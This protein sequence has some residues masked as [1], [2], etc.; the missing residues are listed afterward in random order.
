M[1][2][3]QKFN[4]DLEDRESLMYFILSMKEKKGLSKEK[5]IVLLS[6]LFEEETQNTL[7]DEERKEF[8]NIIFERIN[9]N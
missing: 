8:I 3:E 1:Q 4:I 6:Y 7:S 5:S 9:G 2:L